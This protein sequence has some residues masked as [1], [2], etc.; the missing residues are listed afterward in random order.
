MALWSTFQSTGIVKYDDLIQEPGD[1]LRKQ[2]VVFVA[3]RIEIIQQSGRLVLCSYTSAV[4]FVSERRVGMRPINFK[5]VPF[6]VERWFFDRKLAKVLSDRVG[7]IR[8]FAHT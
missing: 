1:D 2:L 3:A 7:L 6:F 4:K 5:T 8:A